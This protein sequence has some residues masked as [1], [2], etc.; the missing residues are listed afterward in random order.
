MTVIVNLHGGPGAGKS[1]I[2]AHLFALMKQRGINCEYVTEYAKDIVWEGINVRLEN[3]LYI[4]AKQHQKLFRLIGKVDYII[5]DSPLFNSIVYSGQSD[6]FNALVCEEIDRWETRDYF[7]IRGDKYQE[8]GREQNLE[9]AKAVDE[10]ILSDWEK[11][12]PG[13]ELIK[14]NSTEFTAK[15]ILSSLVG[16]DVDLSNF[17]DKRGR[18]WEMFVDECYY[19]MTCV[20]PVGVKDFNNAE[21]FH[22]NT[23][24]EAMEFK[25]LIMKSS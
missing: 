18:E 4:L 11:Y 8:E 19:H 22:F 23:T 5:T 9:Q 6:T 20:R 21:S 2:A 13:K 16:S 24:F 17:K 10:K 3:Q 1:T 15:H 7:I 25:A 14:M 12:L